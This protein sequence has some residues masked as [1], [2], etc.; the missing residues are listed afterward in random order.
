VVG[1]AGLVL[2]TAALASAWAAYVLG[3]TA[4]AEPVTESFEETGS[5]QWVVPAGVCSVSVDVWGAEGGDGAATIPS[6]S[7]IG[8]EPSASD[9]GGDTVSSSG[10][11][12]PLGKDADGGKGGHES[13][14]ITVTPGETLGVQVGSQGQDA[15]GPT[16][17]QGGHGAGDGGDGG[18]ATSSNPA[19]VLSGGGGGGGASSV[20]RAGDELVIAGGGG[21]GGGTG[22]GF[23]SGA[24]VPGGAGGGS[25]ADGTSA[26][27]LSA[28]SP[29]AKGGS[30]GSNGGDGGAG[31]GLTGAED[32]HAGDHEAGGD[33]GT[34][35]FQGG[36]GGGGG[37]TGGGGGGSTGTP[38]NIGGGGGGGGSG[39]GPTG[40]V[41]EDGVRSGDGLVTISYDPVTDACA[42]PAAVVVEPKFTG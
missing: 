3:A 28:T 19:N 35:L 22:N 16:G 20:E 40:V 11:D 34:G 42:A 25:G 32:G 31:A 27:D 1:R 23:V 8:S 12:D 30:S 38:S 2:A 21:G 37:A 13:A 7:I 29:G 18:S 10:I 39:T 17:G 26:P 36:G 5:H 41:S 4:G 14:T 15:S 6:G 9:Q 33:G 24:D